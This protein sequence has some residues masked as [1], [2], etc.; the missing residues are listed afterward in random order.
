[1]LAFPKTASLLVT[2][3]PPNI[4]KDCLDIISNLVQGTVKI[5]SSYSDLT[6]Y[7]LAFIDSYKADQSTEPR[8]A[9]YKYFQN[10]PAPSNVIETIWYSVEQ[11]LK[12]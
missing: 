4:K 9:F 2:S 6:N 12:Q 3:L 11:K 10:Q 7:A 1:M 8:V 5:V